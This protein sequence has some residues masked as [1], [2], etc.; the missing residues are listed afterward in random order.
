[1]EDALQNAMDQS[2]KYPSIMLAST[3]PKKNLHSCMHVTKPCDLSVNCIPS[4]QLISTIQPNASVL[5]KL[6]AQAGP[7][8]EV[9]ITKHSSG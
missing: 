1:M 8:M 3:C 6:K 4:S 7:Y 2:Q 9:W 5:C